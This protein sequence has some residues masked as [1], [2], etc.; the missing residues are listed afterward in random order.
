MNWS[1]AKNLIIV[2]LLLLNI[3]LLSILQLNSMRY[4]L[5][6]DRVNNI[7]QVLQNNNISLNTTLS[8]STAIRRFFGSSE[9]MFAPKYSIKMV[10]ADDI[11]RDASQ[12]F[13]LS[14]ENIKLISNYDH[15]TYTNG[16]ES[17]VIRN[18]S[19]QYQNARGTGFMILSSDV[20]YS[21]A[22]AYISQLHEIFETF[23]HNA[24]FVYDDHIL[25]DF[26][27]MYR[28]HMLYSNVLRIRVTDRGITEVY[29]S[30][31]KPIQFYEHSQ[32]I[33]APDEALLIF[34]T[35]IRN[36]YDSTEH[37]SIT[38]ID[39]VHYKD[40]IQGGQLETIR[41]V[42]HY[43]IYIDGLNNPFLINAFSNTMIH[44]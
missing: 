19:F 8:Y 39:L 43:R 24:T 32:S 4:V 16:S 31:Y 20:A 1:T 40:T 3:L 29:G 11:L 12:Y 22:N 10:H 33:C 27:G 15:I 28:D 5:T 6:V 21:F 9:A 41:A 34:M 2:S 14:H 30:F 38:K 36:I 7:T 18:S 37:I 17:L 25:V 42:P 23:V 13:F 26:R 35:E 44:I